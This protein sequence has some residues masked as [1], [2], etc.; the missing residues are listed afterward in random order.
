VAERSK[1]DYFGTFLD[2]LNQQ[3]DSARPEPNVQKLLAA[4]RDGKPKKVWELQELMGLDL[5]ALSSA[6]DFAGQAGF[7]AVKGRPGQ[8]EVVLTQEGGE[9][10]AQLQV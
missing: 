4:L 2:T 7:V 8:Q 10:A 9:L 3:D 1:N 6:L 5:A